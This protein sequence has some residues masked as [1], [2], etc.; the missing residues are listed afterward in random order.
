MGGGGGGKKKKSSPPPQA[1]P[2]DYNA[3]MASSSAAATAQIG[4]QYKQLI[5]NYPKLEDLT[6]GTVDRLA[7]NLDNQATRDAQDYIR[8]GLAIGDLDPAAA[9]P[10]SIEQALY[11]QGERELALGRSLS[12]EQERAAQQSARAAFAARGLGTS[13]G[14]SAAEILNRDA[15]ASARERERQGF[16]SA[17]ND[18]FV[19]NITNRRLNLANTYFAGA[20]N[21]IAADPYN[22]AVGPGLDYSGG[23]QG[24]QMQQVGNT[25]SSANQMAGNVA[26]FNASML[27]ARR[28]SYLNNQAALQAA[29]ITGGAANQAGW[30]NMIGGLGMGAGSALSGTNFSDKRMKKDI[31]PV[32]KDGVLGLKTYE[33]RFKGESKD[34]PKHTGF[35]AQEVAKVLPEAVEE[36]DYKGKKR[37][38]IKPRVIGQALATAI[39]SQQDAMFNQ[40]YT[41]GKGF[42][43]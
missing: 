24:N 34:A 43:Q 8:R 39:A 23:T 27:D 4:E 30:M 14:S 37:L 7:G 32:G 36:V 16:A 5:A 12:P 26:A 25:F 18:Q 22:R 40:G 35:M 11:D 28:N 17:A 19:N 29:R 31:K 21:L 3:L 42:G 10:T 20:G 1:A 13:M 6:F 33:F 38:A 41:V 15:A 9:D 2:L